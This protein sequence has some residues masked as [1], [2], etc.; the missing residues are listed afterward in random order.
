MQV[1]ELIKKQK[2]RYKT[3]CYVIAGELKKLNIC[4]KCG[5]DLFIECHH[6]DY[7]NAL[8]V[9]WL[10]RKCHYKIHIKPHKEK[11]MT[12]IQARLSDDLK[13]Q[14]ISKCERLGVSQSH[15]IKMLIKEWLNKKDK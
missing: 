12:F 11:D 6:N 14:F 4:E 3:S 1:K 7:E 15:I 8:N 10:C 13:N 9:T 5:S 2:T